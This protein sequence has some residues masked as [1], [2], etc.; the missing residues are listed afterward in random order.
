[1]NATNTM[2][3]QRCLSQLLHSAKWEV[4]PQCL[5]LQ[6]SWDMRWV[7]CCKHCAQDFI[8]QMWAS[9]QIVALLLAHGARVSSC[10]DNWKGRTV[11]LVCLNLDTFQIF[12]G[13]RTRGW[14]FVTGEMPLHYA[15]KWAPQDL[16]HVAMQVVVLWSCIFCQGMATQRLSTC[17]WSQWPMRKLWTSVNLL[18]CIDIDN[19]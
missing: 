1:M 16:K 15:C 4:L 6:E 9:L 5:Q 3:N 10:A 17:C 12:R 13:M 14:T 19:Y 11:P 18:R 8:Y 2:Q 7:K